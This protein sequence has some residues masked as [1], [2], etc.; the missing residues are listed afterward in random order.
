MGAGRRGSL[1]EA[2][3]SSQNLVGQR[4]DH[5]VHALKLSEVEVI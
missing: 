5:R 2:P 4:Q 1:E 3:R